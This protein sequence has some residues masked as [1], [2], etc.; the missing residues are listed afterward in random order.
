MLAVAY[1]YSVCV[2]T[3]QNWTLRKIYFEIK[4]YKFSSLPKIFKQLHLQISYPSQ[5]RNKQL[6][7][8]GIYHFIQV[9]FKKSAVH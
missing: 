5:E 6:R 9:T 2:Y 8:Q 3:Q 4:R 7:Q 1:G